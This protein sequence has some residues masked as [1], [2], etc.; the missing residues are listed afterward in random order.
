[1]AVHWPYLS[2]HLDLLVA[3]TAEAKWEN[4]SRVDGITFSIA[5]IKRGTRGRG[6][7]SRRSWRELPQG[8]PYASIR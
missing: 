1:M 4:M 8:I 2:G 5:Q 7:P 3:E 6:G